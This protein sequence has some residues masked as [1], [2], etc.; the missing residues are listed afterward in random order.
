M[1]AGSRRTIKA[2][3]DCEGWI[4]R[5]RDSVDK[6]EETLVLGVV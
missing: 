2:S 4:L 3:I 6:V 5:C 1:G